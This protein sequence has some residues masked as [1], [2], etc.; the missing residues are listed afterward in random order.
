MMVDGG[1]KGPDSG[2]MGDHGADE[3]GHGED[4]YLM[5]VRNLTFA[6]G[7]FNN[8]CFRTE[9]VLSLQCGNAGTVGYRPFF[10]VRK[11]VSGVDYP[12]DGIS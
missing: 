1:K 8:A 11:P 7:R 2:K 4:G 3:T 5:T 6:A 12:Y 10:C 9:N